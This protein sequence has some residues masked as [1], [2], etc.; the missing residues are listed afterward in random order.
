[1]VSVSCFGVRVAFLLLSSHL[2]FYDF[3]SLLSSL[4]ALVSSLRQVIKVL[5]ALVVPA[6]LDTDKEPGS[7]ARS[8]EEGSLGRRSREPFLLSKP[9]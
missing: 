4:T 7:D 2:C 8:S 5:A 6:F 1:M 3:S 9:V